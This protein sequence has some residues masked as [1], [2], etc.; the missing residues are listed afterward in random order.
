MHLIT[1]LVIVVCGITFAEMSQSQSQILMVSMSGEADI[2]CYRAGLFLLWFILV[3]SVS[4]ASLHC[5]S[6]SCF[7]NYAATRKSVARRQVLLS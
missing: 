4:I 1:F 5:C 3:V 6:A 7:V 2:P